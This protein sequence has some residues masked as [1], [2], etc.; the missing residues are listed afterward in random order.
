[1][2]SISAKMSQNY[3][4]L[5]ALIGA[6]PHTDAECVTAFVAEM[7]KYAARFGMTNTHF[8]NPHGLPEDTHYSCAKDLAKMTMMACAY[9][10]L[11]L[12]WGLPSYSIQVGGPNARTVS[13]SASYKLFSTVSD[14]YHIFGGKSGSI[15]VSGVRYENLTLAVKSKVDDA[16]LVGA[17]MYNT[18]LNPP[19]YPADEK[20]VPLREL[21]DWLEA[22]RQDPTV[23]APTIQ[24]QYASAWV[25]PPHQPEGYW[26]IDLEMVGKSSTAQARPASTTKIMTC[27]VALDHLSLNENITIHA[28]DIQSGSGDTYYE[29]DIIN[30]A[31]AIVAMMLPSSNTLATALARAAGN[32]ILN[33]K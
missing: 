4:E 3:D 19:D 30:V 7:N 14:Y 1:M 25:I 9:G 27:L 29:G 24:A 6:T 20:G 17:I 28:S 31:D 12:L 10:K 16:W 15:T 22:Y 11:Q 13:G 18:N 33:G 23:T 5:L 26:D 2:S 32:R 21:F 8:D